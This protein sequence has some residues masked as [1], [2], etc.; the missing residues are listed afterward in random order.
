MISIWRMC[1]V[2]APLLLGAAPM[3]VAQQ[4][5]IFSSND[6]V[7]PVWSRSGMV[8]TQEARATRIGVEIL[9]QGGNAVDAAVAVGFALAVTLPRA[10]NLGG[11]GFMIIHDATLEET[12][13]LDYREKAPAAAERDMYL[14]SDGN[15]DKELSRF[16]GLAVGVPGTV[17]GLIEALETHG[18]MPLADV[19]APAIELAE[20]GIVVSAAMAESL[21][22]L[23]DRLRKWPSSA[24][25]FY[26]EDGGFYEAG[27]ILVQADLA[28]SLRL[29]AE[30]GDAAFYN[31]SIGRKIVAAVT[32]AGG[33][34]SQTDLAN[35]ES[36]VRDVVRGTYRGYEIAS[37]PPPSSG[38]VHIVQILNIL[39]GYP[40]GFLGHNSAETIHLMAEA[41]K[42]A[43]ADRSE[44]LGDS[45]FC[46]CPHRRSDEQSLRGS[47]ARQD[48]PQQGD[49]VINNQTRQPNSLR[50]ERNDSFLHHRQGRQRGRQYLYDQF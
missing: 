20:N 40:I 30:Q 4:S 42:L 50:V 34:M 11:G 14:D 33:I 46:R 39:E 25:V 24:K 21:K 2:L 48:Q 1:A 6:R 36:K 10:G 9:E 12:T 22:S 5:A 31:G 37:M 41:M 8:A 13:A 3:A 27:E 43:Y 32:E 7:H 16:H 35:Y 19:L 23:E 45:D 49:A 47:A 17:A 29:I 44:Y 38:G 15:P 28:N 18:T 26:K